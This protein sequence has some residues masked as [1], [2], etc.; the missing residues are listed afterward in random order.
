MKDSSPVGSINMLGAKIELASQYINKPNSFA[1]FAKP[2][3]F[4]MIADSYYI[5][6]M[7]TNLCSEAD[8][9]DWIKALQAAGAIDEDA[10]KREEEEKRQQ[11]AKEK[12]EQRKKELENEKKIEAEYIKNAKALRQNIMKNKQEKE[13]YAASLDHANCYCK[14]TIVNTGESDADG[15]M[16]TYHT[17]FEI[18]LEITIDYIGD[19]CQHCSSR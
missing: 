6:A 13:Q 12:R 16:V 11:E 8:M 15:V 17:Q 1:I 3:D 10:R 7:K 5:K 18:V 2:K 4:F 14:M 9:K 19:Q